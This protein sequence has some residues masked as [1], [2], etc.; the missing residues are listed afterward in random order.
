MG[1][2]RRT[3]VLNL[4]AIRDK[5]D[6]KC[7]EKKIAI[8]DDVRNAVIDATFAVIRG[9]L[10]SN[11]RKHGDFIDI[12]GL[13][14]IYVE[15]DDERT[16]R[17]PRSGEYLAK[18]KSRSLKFKILKVMKD[19]LEEKFEKKPGQKTK[20]ATTAKNVER[21]EALVKEGKATD[22]QKATLKE[23]KKPAAD[24]A[25]AKPAAEAKPAAKP[26]AEKKAGLTP[27]AKKTVK[28]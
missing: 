23:L 3:N 17:I 9:S 2:T 24:K 11:N 25:A 12:P 16:V 26:A 14:R 8:H 13:V 18:G 10:K 22:E 1:R 15:E 19:Q 27:A 7:T 5:V 21:L 6:Q 28:K 20:D 4:A